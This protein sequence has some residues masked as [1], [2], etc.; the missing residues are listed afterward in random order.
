MNKISDPSTPEI[1]E[2]EFAIDQWRTKPFMPHVVARFRPLA[3]QKT[4]LMKYLNNLI[5]WGD[6]LFR[7]DT[8]ES[9]TQATP[10]VYFG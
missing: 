3:Y 4:L 8:M 1:K 9:V 7:Q 10:D 5:E 6:Y 2:L